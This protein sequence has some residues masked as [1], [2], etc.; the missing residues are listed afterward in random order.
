[1]KIHEETKDR[2]KEKKKPAKR[3]R[4]AQGRGRGLGLEPVEGVEAREEQE[5]SVEVRGAEEEEVVVV[6]RQVEGEQ[7]NL[8]PA[9][10]ALDPLEKGFLAHAQREQSRMNERLLQ[11]TYS[12]KNKTVSSFM[13][14]SIYLFAYI[15]HQHLSYSWL[16]SVVQVSWLSPLKITLT[17]GI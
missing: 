6:R 16:V 4:Q 5:L 1:M 7:E 10:A 17:A 14:L 13:F 2:W 3:Q 11:R 8:V 9:A 15:L 12:K